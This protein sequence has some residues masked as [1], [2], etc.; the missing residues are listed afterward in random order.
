MVCV[1]EKV[2]NFQGKFGGHCEAPRQQVA[3]ALPC[4]LLPE[5]GNCHPGGPT[6]FT[7]PVDPTRQRLM[8]G[9]VVHSRLYDTSNLP[10]CA[11]PQLVA[12]ILVYR[13]CVVK[14]R[15]ASSH[16][17][18]GR[19]RPRH[20]IVTVSRSRHA[21]ANRALI[22]TTRGLIPWLV[23]NTDPARDVELLGT[24]SSS[25]ALNQRNFYVSKRSTHCR[26]SELV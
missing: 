10:A 3:G 13:P 25:T 23:F 19:P 7:A 14:V 15:S 16:L 8:P 22:R 12:T 6:L 1:Q 18:N 21:A 20:G 5:Q 24:A 2:V 11:L 17:V 9:S 26:R 4:G